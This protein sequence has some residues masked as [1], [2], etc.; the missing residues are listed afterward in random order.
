MAIQEDFVV[1]L[2]LHFLLKLFLS[3]F[4]NKIKNSGKFL[5]K[6]KFLI[7]FASFAIVLRRYF[8]QLEAQTIR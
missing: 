2:P 6:L 4:K 5:K 1:W 7:K 8:C 3:D